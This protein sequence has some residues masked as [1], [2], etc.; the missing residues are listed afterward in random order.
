[1]YSRKFGIAILVVEKNYISI[2][3][4]EYRDSY[5]LNTELLVC[6]QFSSFIVLFYFDFENKNSSNFVG[7]C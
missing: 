5:Y 6:I 3:L 4:V 1:M 7:Y 2:A